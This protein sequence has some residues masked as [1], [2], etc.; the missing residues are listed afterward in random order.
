MEMTTVS[1][2]CVFLQSGSLAAFAFS[3]AAKAEIEVASM[4]IASI[5]VIV[6]FI[7]APFYFPTFLKSSVVHR[8]PELLFRD[9]SHVDRELSSFRHLRLCDLF[10]FSIAQPKCS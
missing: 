2:Y 6:L 5:R 10:Q 4:A 1:S 7:S 8:C 3:D 9:K